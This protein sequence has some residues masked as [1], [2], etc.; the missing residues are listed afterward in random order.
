MKKISLINTL[1]KTFK[2]KKT[3]VNKKT[4]KKLV[5]IKKGKIALKPKQKKT[6]INVSVDTKRENYF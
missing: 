1:K 5:N 6:L 3:Q 4:K 2:S